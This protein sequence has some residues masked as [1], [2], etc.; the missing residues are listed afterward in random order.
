MKYLAQCRAGRWYC[1]VEEED[2]VAGVDGD[3]GGDGYSKDDDSG[4]DG[5]GVGKGDEDDNGVMV[6]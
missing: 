3:D 4:D 2:T 1:D 6:M 5:D